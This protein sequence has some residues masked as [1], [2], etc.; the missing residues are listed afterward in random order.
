MSKEL[1]YKTKT[2]LTEIY[3]LSRTNRYIYSTTLSA[4]PPWFTVWPVRLA[5]Y[6]HIP[7]NWRMPTR[8]RILWDFSHLTAPSAVHLTTCFLPDSQ[9]HRFSVKALLPLSPLQ[10]F[11]VL[12][13]ILLYAQLSILSMGGRVVTVCSYIL[14]QMHLNLTLCPK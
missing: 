10:Q 2:P 1:S 4:V 13:Y 7:D 3:T 14:F 8:C 12:N 11:E 6:Q 9:Q 5:G